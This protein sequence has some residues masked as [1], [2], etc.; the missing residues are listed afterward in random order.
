MKI[1]KKF[2]FVA[3]FFGIIVGVICVASV[4]AQT[5]TPAPA[6]VQ[7]AA[8]PVSVVDPARLPH[9][10]ADVVRLSHAG[11]G[12]DTIVAFIQSKNS[13]Y[14]LGTQ[15]ILYLKDQGVSERVI[16]AMIQ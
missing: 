7:T 11:I 8:P 9:G 3:G 4:R 5:E 2:S 16:S 15:E 14:G 1:I 12:E 13:Q 10:V 6:T